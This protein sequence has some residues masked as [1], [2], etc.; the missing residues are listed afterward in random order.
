MRV[1]KDDLLEKLKS[2]FDHWRAHPTAYTHNTGYDGHG[3]RS[4]AKATMPDFLEA[5][6][7]FDAYVKTHTTYRARYAASLSGAANNEW[8]YLVEKDGLAKPLFN[9]HIGI[10]GTLAITIAG[11]GASYGDGPEPK[12]LS[13][14]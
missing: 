11:D 3:V 13:G 1:S 4:F 12:G 6:A 7:A 10:M 8:S 9:F 2:E 5:F 14:C